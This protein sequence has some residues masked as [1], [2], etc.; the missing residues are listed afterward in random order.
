MYNRGIMQ[1]PAAMYSRNY[2]NLGFE[3]SLIYD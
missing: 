3:T 1:L 2:Q